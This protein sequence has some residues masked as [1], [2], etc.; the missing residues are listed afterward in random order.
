MRKRSGF[1]LPTFGSQL[2]DPISRELKTR[3]CGLQVHNNRLAG[4]R[5]FEMDTAQQ[6]SEGRISA[7]GHHDAG[8]LRPP[9]GA[10]GVHLPSGSS[11]MTEYKRGDSAVAFARATPPEATSLG[12]F[13]QITF[14]RE[15]VPE[16]DVVNGTGFCNSLRGSPG[17][18]SKSHLLLRASRLCFGKEAREHYVDWVF[19][20]LPLAPSFWTQFQ[21]SPIT[22]QSLLAG[23][24]LLFETRIANK[25]LLEDHPCGQCCEWRRDLGG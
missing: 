16:S 21:E 25:S 23:S 7:R 10:P 3:C 9:G 2:L 20:Y 13:F 1:L 8:S 11:L 12:A 19:F 22:K 18:L 6:P 24:R 5:L 14:I 17:N 15:P 4:S